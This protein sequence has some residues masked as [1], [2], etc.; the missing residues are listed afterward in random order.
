MQSYIKTLKKAPD[1]NVLT[2][3]RIFVTLVVLL[4][5]IPVLAQNSNHL[6]QISEAYSAGEIDINEAVIKQIEILRSSKHNHVPGEGSSHI[7]CA[8]PVL[9]LVNKYKNELTA[10]T[11]LTVNSFFSAK[12][13]SKLAQ[14]YI[15]ES[16]KFKF[17]FETV[18]SDAVPTAD[19]N[20]NS[21]PDY[22]EWAAEAADSSYRHEIETLGFTDPIPA[23]QTYNIAFE[24]LGGAYG[25]ATTDGSQPAGTRIVIEN[26]F[27]GFPENTDP[28]GN[29][30]GALKVTI[31]HEFKHAIQYA[32]ND[33]TGDSDS[34]AEMDATL[35]EEV[36]YDNVND[37]YNYISGFGGDLFSS[38]TSSL[39]PGS[40]EDITWALYFHERYGENTWPDIWTRIEANASLSLLDAVSAEMTSIGTTFEEAA[41]ESYMWHFASG[42]SNSTSSFGFEERNDYPSPTIR[43]NFTELQSELS[44]TFVN[45]RFSASYFVMDPTS[46]S[47]GL[48]KFDYQTSSSDVQIGIIVYKSDQTVETQLITSPIGGATQTINTDWKWNEID[49]IGLVFVN[50]NTTQS[51]SF[52]FA[53]ADYFINGID[54]LDVPSAI[55]LSQNF[56]NPFNP[57]TQIQLTLP[58]SQ[59]ISLKVYDYQ[60]RLVQTLFEGTLNRGFHT[61]PFDG[62]NLASGI[63]FYTLVSDQGTQTKRMT[64]LK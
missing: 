11:Q 49:R 28:E 21:I 45:T 6:L 9:M 26:D 13:K 5:G 12:K 39:I 15:S 60:G 24:N 3:K 38:P 23:G 56:P 31:A 44:D 40:Y 48:V 41:L 63:Y 27:V 43:R 35:M 59:E 32:M 52:S 29:Q 50:T 53:L 57:G 46:S 17:S 22:V 33:W 42:S 2:N 4:M 18:G 37:Y 55:E 51:S 64:L 30:K 14:D 7:K 1:L 58:S 25:F 34:W 47:D 36:V 20:G 19:N 8:T 54:T 61:V 10:E 16:G 62:S